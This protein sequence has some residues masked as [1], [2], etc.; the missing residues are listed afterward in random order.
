MDLPTTCSHTHPQCEALEPHLCNDCWF[1][2]VQQGLNAAADKL[3]HNGV[4][5]RPHL[6]GAVAA[7]AAVVVMLAV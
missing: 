2:V 4:E 3:T 6:E 1:H 5:S 7:R